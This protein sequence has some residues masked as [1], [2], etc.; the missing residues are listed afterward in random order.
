MYTVSRS[1]TVGLFFALQGA[2]NKKH[3]NGFA[4]DTERDQRRKFRVEKKLQ[5]MENIQEKT[6]VDPL[7]DNYHDILEFAENYFNAHERSPEG[8]CTTPVA[9]TNGRIR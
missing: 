8:T 1:K 6:N 2:A 7:H 3:S 9:D 5:E 4:E